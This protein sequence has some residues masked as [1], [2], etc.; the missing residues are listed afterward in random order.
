MQRPRLFKGSD[1]N[2]LTQD[3]VYAHSNPIFF[4]GGLQSTIIIFA[5]TNPFLPAV[6]DCGVMRANG[7]AVITRARLRAPIAVSARRAA[8]AQPAMRRLPPRS[9]PRSRLLSACDTTIIIA[10]LCSI[11]RLQQA[12]LVFSFFFAII[13]FSVHNNR[14]W[15][16]VHSRYSVAQCNYPVAVSQRSLI[17]IALHL[18]LNRSKR[19]GLFRVC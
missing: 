7:G 13:K 16:K 9:S 1:V 19:R 11:R 15:Q 2:Y 17:A 4:E 5:K 10:L 18:I 6:R 8:P 12:R 3:P 14:V